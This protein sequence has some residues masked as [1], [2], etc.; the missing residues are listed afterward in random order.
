M[1][2]TVSPADLQ[3]LTELEIGDQGPVSR[4]IYSRSDDELA[5]L[6]GNL[7]G[8]DLRAIIE[9]FDAIDAA[10]GRFRR[11]GRR[12][13][14]ALDRSLSEPALLRAGI[15]GR[16]CLAQAFEPAFV[17]ELVTR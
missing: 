6:M 8:H 17:D 1:A 13:A 3:I 2:D 7:G 10:A 16:R 14:A 5:R 4:L 15:P 12:D 9:A 11:A